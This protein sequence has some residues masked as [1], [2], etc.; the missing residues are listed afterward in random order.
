MVVGSYREYR[1]GLGVSTIGE[2]AFPPLIGCVTAMCDKRLSS[3]C[4]N[5]LLSAAL[6]RAILP[7][8]SNPPVEAVGRGDGA[9][10]ARVV[11]DSPSFSMVLSATTG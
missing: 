5:A 2:G 7:T 9:K 6:W 8:P 3:C 1:G 11:G 4:G 10:Y